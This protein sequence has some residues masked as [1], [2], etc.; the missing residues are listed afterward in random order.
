VLQQVCQDRRQFIDISVCWTLSGS[1]Y[2]CGY[3]DGSICTINYPGGQ[4]KQI[5]SKPDE[6][7]TA[8]TY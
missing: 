2:L 6:V 4:K 8:G 5:A 3:A 7:T 1:Q